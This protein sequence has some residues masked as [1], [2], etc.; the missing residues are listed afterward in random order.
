MFRY[1]YMTLTQIGELFGVTS[2]QIGKW[3]VWIKL[4]TEA[5]RPSSAAFDGKFVSQGPSRGDGYNWVW[6][7]ARTVAAL[8]EAGH[9][10]I[11]NPP[12]Y[13]ADPS[14][15]NGPFTKRANEAN[16]YDLVGGDGSVAIVVAGEKNVDF[17]LQLLNLADKHGTV[18][19]AMQ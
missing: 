1:E 2:H 19:R 18:A 9:R 13:L 12:P 5:K 6:H 15:L 11:F 4:R 16:G 14:K 10:R 8:E 7:A 17:V 3:L